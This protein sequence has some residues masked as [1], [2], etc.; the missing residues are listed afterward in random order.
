M[1]NI[2]QKQYKYFLYSQ[3]QHRLCDEIENNIG[4]EYIPG[5]VMYNGKWR[6]FTEISSTSSNNKYSDAKVVSEGYIEDIQ[7]KLPT[8]RWRAK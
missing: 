6:L 4:R 1:A 3:S 5:K 7:Y 8:R 2:K